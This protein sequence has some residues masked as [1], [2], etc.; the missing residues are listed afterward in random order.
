MISAVYYYKEKK[1]LMMVHYF[2]H[3]K[4]RLQESYLYKSTIR[5]NHGVAVINLNFGEGV[6]HQCFDS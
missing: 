6:D 1:E 2:P 4:I 3:G 5:R